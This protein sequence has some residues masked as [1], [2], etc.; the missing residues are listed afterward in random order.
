[1]YI[2]LRRWNLFMEDN[3]RCF[4]AKGGALWIDHFPGALREC[5]GMIKTD[6]ESITLQLYVSRHLFFRF[7]G[8]RLIF[9]TLIEY[10]ILSVF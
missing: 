7:I 5:C 9:Y 1:M 2:Q 4:W 10:K 3:I 6:Y 8:D